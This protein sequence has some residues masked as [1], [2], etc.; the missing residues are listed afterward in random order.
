MLLPHSLKTLAK[1][2]DGQYDKETPDAEIDG[3]KS[4]KHFFFFK[5]SWPSVRAQPDFWAFVKVIAELCTKLFCYQ[6]YC[7]AGEGSSIFQTK[8]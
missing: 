2:D 3:P 6:L 1:R 8:A 5:L 7:L 4:I